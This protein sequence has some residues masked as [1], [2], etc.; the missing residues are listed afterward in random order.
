MSQVSVPHDYTSAIDFL[1]ARINY[2]LTPPEPRRR[3][4]LDQMRLLLARLGNP[5][6]A[7]PA[8]H[9][10]GTKGKGSTAAMVSSALT[11]AGY[12]TGLYTS[13][14]LSC[15][16]ER[17]MVDGE[18]CTPAELVALVE[19]IRPAVTEV[20]RALSLSQPGNCLTFFEVTTAMAWQFFARKEVDLAVVEVGLGGRLDS[21]NLCRPLV[22]AIT[23]ISFDHM[24]QLGNTLAAIAR[25]KAGIIKPGVP[26]VSGIAAPE[27]RDVVREIAAE[28]QSVLYELNTDYNI[29]HV[30]EPGAGAPPRFDYDGVVDGRTW[31]L[32]DIHIGL[33]GRHQAHN[34]GVALTALA[35]LHNR[36]V[37]FN[38]TAYRAGF[39]AARCPARIEIVSRRPVVILDTAH[40]HASIRALIET[41]NENFPR[42]RRVLIFAASRDKDVRAM[43]RQ[44]VSQFD[45]VMLTQ[46]IT[47][48]RAVPAWELERTATE[49]MA[50]TKQPRASLLLH[51][52]T[53]L[54]AWSTCRQLLAP[55]DLACVSGSFFL[56]AEMQPLLADSPRPDSGQG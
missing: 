12:R 42:G 30:V 28:R 20:D 24:K 38:E 32:D 53:P 18:R 29:T 48:P 47:N 41:L 6:D 40:N 1:Y 23:S 16:E 34:A 11:Q 9:I 27:A 39:S 55:D 46:F 44:L 50:A 31:H 3:L 19:S 33:L 26:V 22:A 43:L 52:S 56:A 21:T 4:S 13:P 45:T 37:P 10:A 8:I 25:E 54:A 2:E 5:Q 51:C 17:F 14:H 35:S 36:K 49:V 7:V 15:L